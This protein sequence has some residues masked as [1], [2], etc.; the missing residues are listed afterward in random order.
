MAAQVEA[1]P[2]V[3]RLGYK[4]KGPQGLHLHLPCLAVG[5]DLVEVDD[6]APPRARWFGHKEGARYPP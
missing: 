4:T 2:V 1:D 5:V 3:A 6:E